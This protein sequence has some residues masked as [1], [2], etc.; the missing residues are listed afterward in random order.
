MKRIMFILALARMPATGC[1]LV[2]FLLTLM[3]CTRQRGYEESLSKADSLMNMAPDSSLFILDSLEQ[4]AQDFS[5]SNFRRWQLLRMMAQNK[6]DTIFRSDSLQLVLANYYDRHGTPNERMT[7]HYL[8]GRAYSDMGEAP[9]A[10]RAY[11]KAVN[12]AD[13]TSID[14]DYRTLC[15]ILGQEAAIFEIQR[16]PKEQIEAL[17]QYSHFA[18]KDGRIYDCIRGLEM[19]I[20]AWYALDDT[21]HCF[22]LTDEC[23]KLYL[24]NGMYREAESVYPTAI[25]ILLQD[26]LYTRARTLMQAF[27]GKSGL[28]DPKGEI[29]KGR[30]HYYNSKGVY[31]NGVNQVDSAE[32]FFRKLAGY[33]IAFNYDAYLGLLE[34]YIKRGFVDSIAKYSK[35]AEIALDSIHMQNQADATALAVSIYNYTKKEEFALEMM[36]EADDQKQKTERL[37]MSLVIFLISAIGGFFILMNRKNK[38]VNRKIQ[39]I[40]LL[41]KTI[42]QME[43]EKAPNDRLD[44]FEESH[45]VKRIRQRARKNERAGGD[46]LGELR[47][48]AVK[49]LP[50]FMQT[51]NQTGYE[52]QINET[53]LCILIKAKFRPSEIAV[54]MN[55]SP[56]NITNLRA[57]LNKK[58]FHADKGAKDFNEKIINLSSS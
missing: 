42:A 34:V 10:I 21:A 39:E 28:F 50:V 27:E 14:C 35:L 15:A 46:E 58:M 25:L 38:I 48:A 7:A 22:R 23:H 36:K 44:E 47:I 53:I 8:L 54:L 41:Q 13:T 20:P 9:D 49:H 19:Q 55:L 1:I 31:Y 17:W 5:K 3:A 26:S 6:C 29:Q 57:R 37:R 43:E 40:E 12:Y 52:L 11:L 56:Q 4:S 18:N 32:F 2:V 33:D 24:E 51:L 16:M 30:E 45:I